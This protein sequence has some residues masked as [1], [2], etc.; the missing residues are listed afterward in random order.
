MFSKISRRHCKI[1][2]DEKHGWMVKENDVPSASGTWLH[3]KTYVKARVDVA[4]SQPVEIY[5]GMEI[6][7]NTYVFKLSFTA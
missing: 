6:Q 1:Y 7:A 2:Y 3:L 4:N 5:N